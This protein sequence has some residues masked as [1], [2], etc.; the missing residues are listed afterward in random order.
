MDTPVGLQAA[1]KYADIQV[2]QIPLDGI[3]LTMKSCTNFQKW[4][5]QRI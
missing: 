3:F 2:M 5:F 4:H 1:C